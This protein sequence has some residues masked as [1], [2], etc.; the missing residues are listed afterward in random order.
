MTL[1]SCKTFLI[2]LLCVLNVSTASS[3][4]STSLANST[5]NPS[6]AAAIY[7][8]PSAN[9]IAQRQH[10]RD[11]RSALN[12]KKVDDYKKH[13]AQLDEYP[14]AA[15]LDYRFHLRYISQFNEDKL[16]RFTKLHDNPR[17]TRRL[18]HHW[19]T[20]MAKNKQ[21]DNLLTH[22]SGSDLSTELACHHAQAQY[23][24]QQEEKAFKEAAVLWLSPKSLPASCDAILHLL[25]KNGR[26]T[27]E[28]GWQ[29]F[30]LAFAAQNQPLAKYLVRF[31]NSDHT[32]LAETM[33]QQYRQPKQ[34]A[35]QWHKLPD[36]S[37]P[38]A[39]KAYKKS[40]LLLLKRLARTDAKSA[41]K[42][43]QKQRKSKKTSDAKQVLLE[44]IRP[45]MIRQAALR[46]YRKVP[47]RYRQIGSPEDKESL[48]WMIRSQLHL[49]QWNTIPPLIKQLPE[50]A[51]NSDRWQYWL[52]RSEELGGKTKKVKKRVENATTVD[53]ELIPSDNHDKLRKANFYGFYFA[54]QTR[55]DYYLKPAAIAFNTEIRS[56]LFAIPGIQRSLEH[57][58]QNEIHPARSEWHRAIRQLDTEQ[59]IHAGYLANQFGLHNSAIN[60]MVN[61]GAWEHYHIRFPEVYSS[62]FKTQ[63]MRY[64]YPHQWLFATARQESALAIDAQSGAGAIG[65]MQIIPSTAKAVAK[66]LALPYKKSSLQSPDTSILLGSRYLFELHEKYQNRALA[67]AAYNAGPHRIDQ[68]L[69]R[70]D[71]PLP[72]D[73]WI[74]TIPFSETRQYVQ[75]ILSFSLIHQLL[76]ENPTLPLNLSSIESPLF[77]EKEAMVQ[78]H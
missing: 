68:W 21:W 7:P 9:I 77:F 62:Q 64:N 29:R 18:K 23:K 63:A 48:E 39:E 25:V 31:L 66:R 51:R 53:G 61:A 6:D 49:A 22:S 20:A 37:I 47:Q 54:K 11:A 58:A 59:Q 16:K 26:V 30:T 3:N 73:A 33:L 74:E 17:L 45:Y 10:Y 40:K 50:K 32:A 57:F 76:Y 12:D 70:L 5:G 38:A 36:T 65:L 67:S 27:K 13:R 78:P 8:Y 43:V 4:N 35:R 71:K 24:T 19:L 41:A 42:Y 46:D 75:N 52:M 34:I 56:A 60:T 72:L 69:K 14:L 2:A 55:S 44:E 28:M 1:S 15:Y